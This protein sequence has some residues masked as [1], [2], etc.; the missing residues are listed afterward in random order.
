MT[1]LRLEDFVD[2]KPWT[3][4]DEAPRRFS[5]P[6]QIEGLV[7]VTYIIARAHAGCGGPPLHPLACQ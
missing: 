1:T 3:P 7:G 6:E 5:I 4:A 2:D